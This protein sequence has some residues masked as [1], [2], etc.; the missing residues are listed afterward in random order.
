MII[1]I[2]NQKGG[3]GKSTIAQSLAGGLNR[4]QGDRSLVIDLDPQ[5][6]LTYIS[7]FEPR[8]IEQGAFNLING[9]KDIRDLILQGSAYDIIP[10]TKDLA[11]IR[12]TEGSIRNLARGL[13]QVIENYA[14]VI[15]DTPPN[16]GVLSVAALSVSGGAIVPVRADILSIR[17]LTELASTIEAIKDTYNR[18]LRILGIVITQHNSRTNLGREMSE[19]LEQAAQ[20]LDTTVYE[21][22]IREAVAVREAQVNQI[23][24]WEHAPRAN[25]TEDILGLIKEIARQLE[26]ESNK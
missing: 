25:V 24:V 20:R 17:G 21:N 26:R 1:T 8:E 9:Y 7:G 15:I 11:V 22:V 6:N 23:P 3:V 14:H 16:L 2:A 12:D 4:L 5:G 19:Q 18:N 13:L 10:A